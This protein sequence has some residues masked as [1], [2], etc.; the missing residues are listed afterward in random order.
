MRACDL[1]RLNQPY[2]EDEDAPDGLAMSALGL[3]LR[4]WKELEAL[5]VDDFVEQ[6]PYGIGWWAPHPGT[7]R[8]ILIGDQLYA[9]VA[10]VSANMTEAVLHWLEYQDCAERDSER[11][12]DIVQ[13][14]NGQFD[15]VLPSPRNAME[16]LSRE[17]V[18]M[19]IAGVARAL[20]AALDCLA[21]AIIG[22]VAVPISILKADW[23][24]LETAFS[25]I[26]KGTTTGEQA[27]TDFYTK[28]KDVVASAGPDG[29]LNW[30]LD[31]RNMLVHRGRR[32]E[33]GQFVPKVPQLYG[34]DGE[35]IPRVR[36]LTFLPRNPGMS[37]VEVWR[38]TPIAPVRDPLEALV[39]NEDAA[40]TLGGL[41]DST[42][43]VISETAK[44]LTEVWNWRRENPQI[45]PQPAAQWPRGAATSPELVF[46]GYAP[47]ARDLSSASASFH[48][49][50]IRRFRAASLDDASRSRWDTFD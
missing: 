46:Q 40:Q 50:D 23:G 5:I 33:T 3:P 20:S 14:R 31:F 38:E 37:D 41:L 44:L 6:A 10:S 43:V 25:K 39:L 16:E 7:S 45:L 49:I 19:H 15:V 21:G 9:C 12:A 13:I 24:K 18:V 2:P 47:G 26:S 27:Q 36:R 4:R 34:P 30:A 28:L 29:W 11:F 48:P 1:A 22:V 42:K 32:L 35:Q 8:R 17:M